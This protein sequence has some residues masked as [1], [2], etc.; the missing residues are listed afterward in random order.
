MNW[1]RLRFVVRQPVFVLGMLC[2]CQASIPLH[3]LTSVANPPAQ[4]TLSSPL[5]LPV[6][7]S[8]TQPGLPPARFDKAPVPESQRPKSGIWSFA[9]DGGGRILPRFELVLAF[10]G[11]GTIRVI[12]TPTTPKM[13][14]D[15]ELESYLRSSHTAAG[16][17][18]IAYLQVDRLYRLK[19]LSPTQM[20]GEAWFGIKPPEIVPIQ[21][22]W[23]GPAP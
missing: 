9:P 8:A 15:G 6:N 1:A 2:G 14:T 13:A 5:F 22:E 20:A 21:A 17:D 18:W 10:D 3:P 16:D 19:V 11:D 4:T 12:G 7:Q 23:L